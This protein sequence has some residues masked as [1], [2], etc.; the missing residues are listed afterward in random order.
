MD[1]QAARAVGSW[2]PGHS[3]L[4]APLASI[5]PIFC[6]QPPSPCPV[7]TG[8]A[9]SS[10]SRL[11]QQAELAPTRG[12]LSPVGSPLSATATLICC[13]DGAETDRQWI[14]ALPRDPQQLFKWCRFTQIAENF[15]TSSEKPISSE[16]VK[17]Q[18][19]PWDGW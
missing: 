18:I 4:Q 10:S 13:C 17:Q 6:S 15:L 3:G 11:D 8:F 14:T 1:R 9:V 16:H 5:L 12:C 7:S 19:G 2:A